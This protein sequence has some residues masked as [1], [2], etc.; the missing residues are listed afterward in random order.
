MTDARMAELKLQGKLLYLPIGKSKR[1]PKDYFVACESAT[2]ALAYLQSSAE[3]FV[4]WRAICYRCRV[5][6][7]KTWKHRPNEWNAKLKHGLRE[8]WDIAHY[9]YFRVLIPIDRIAD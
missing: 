9:D 3:V 8:Y 5:S 2:E 7:I 6:S 1:A 4:R